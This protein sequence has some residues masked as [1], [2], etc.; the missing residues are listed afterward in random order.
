MSVRKNKR[1]WWIGSFCLAGCLLVGIYWHDQSVADLRATFF[2]IGQGDSTLIQTPS[3]QSIL[4]DAGPDTTVLSKLGET[5]PFYD[6]R[7]DLVILTHCHADHEGGLAAVLE[8]Y[9]VG[10]VIWSGVGDQSPGCVAWQDV[11]R[12]K[13]IPVHVVSAGER[14]DFGAAEMDIVYPLN[15]QSVASYGKDLNMTSLV[16]RLTYQDTSFLFTGDAPVEIEQELLKQRNIT[17]ASDVLKVGH[18][19]SRYSSSLEFLQA[20]RP[21]FVVISVGAGNSYGHPHLAVLNRLAYL[22]INTLRTDEYGDVVCV[23]DG[24]SVRCQ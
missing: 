15:H 13:K 18:H 3:H 14:Y 22:G 19:G 8:R 16:S 10:Q 21:Q 4:I 20:I 11:S 24:R 1:M 2:D 6:R 5:L 7:I 17:L 9:D 12:Q 23:S